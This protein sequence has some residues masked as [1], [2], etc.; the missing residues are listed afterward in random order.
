[1]KKVS[2]ILF[3]VLTGALVSGAVRGTLRGTPATATFRDAA[4]DMVWMTGKA[5]TRM[6]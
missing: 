5:L 6:A 4:A 1:M 2:W 3:F